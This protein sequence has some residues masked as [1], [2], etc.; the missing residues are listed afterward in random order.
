MGDASGTDRRRG[1]EP[2]KVLAI[3]AFALACLAFSPTSAAAQTSDAASPAVVGKGPPPNL[4]TLPEGCDVAARPTGDSTVET[5]Y[6]NCHGR[7]L[8]LGRATAY[9]VF[10]NPA[11]NATVVDIRLG[12]ERRVLLLSLG[13]DG[14]PLLEDISGDIAMAADK[15]PMGGI[16][17]VAVDFDSFANDATLGVHS[18]ISGNVRRLGLGT[19]LARERSR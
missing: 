15:G 1:V 17:S 19:Q 12:S 8:V 10:S 2:R 9:R 14:R 4:V 6:A 13:K 18:P 3:S 7:G 5:I 11:L 16:A